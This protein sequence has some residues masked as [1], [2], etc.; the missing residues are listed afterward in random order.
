MQCNDRQLARLQRLL[1]EHAGLLIQPHQLP[2]LCDAV[3]CGCETFQLPD[4]ESYL[5][6]VVQGDR[7]TPELADLLAR[8]TIGE[9]YFF[10]DD[11]QMRFL[12]DEWLPE[13]IEQRPD[14]HRPLRI[15]SAGTSAGQEIYTLAMLLQEQLPDRSSWQIEL[16]GTDINRV[17]LAQAVEGRYSNWSLR[18]IP[19]H[20]RRHYF[21]YDKGLYQIDPR[22]QQQVRFSYLNLAKDHFPS[23][24]NH[25]GSIDLILCRNVF[26]YFDPRQI[27]GVL[28][29]FADSLATGGY[30]LLGAAD[31]IAKEIVDLSIRPCGSGF[32]FQRLPAVTPPPQIAAPTNRRLRSTAAESVT[33]TTTT[34][35]PSRPTIATSRGSNRTQLAPLRGGYTPP[36]HHRYRD[37]IRLLR[38]EQWLQVVKRIDSY[39][40]SGHDHTDFAQFRAHALTHLGR[41]SEA[42]TEIEQA[43]RR[44]PLDQYN[45]LIRARV[46]LQLNQQERA[47]EALRQAIYLEPTSVEAHYQLGQL[48]L[49]QGDR[50]G[51]LQSL[52][53]ALRLAEPID[54]T[55]WVHHVSS[56]RFGRLTQMVR[57]ALARH[58]RTATTDRSRF[59]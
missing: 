28:T 9:S 42:A 55:Q 13:I 34:V 43:L 31:P 37:L 29:R 21:R 39:R 41:L 26:I 48:L 24:F 8:V 38:S 11:E 1:C 57:E 35:A 6:R 49:Q 45:H 25:T 5:Q 50:V 23:H 20:Y 44:Q 54:P 33:S 10:R 19:E 40:N 51:S 3:R 22:L 16:L 47:V 58:P 17:A 7:D 2:N 30:L 18:N 14:R 56:L 53:E 36:S 12:Q 59:L 4:V 46:L 27:S 32:C 52:N 15:W